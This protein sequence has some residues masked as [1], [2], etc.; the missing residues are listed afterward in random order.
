MVITLL[1]LISLL[2]LGVP[3]TVTSK[4]FNFAESTP[5]SEVGDLIEEAFWTCSKDMSIDILSSE[6]VLPSHR[7]RVAVEDLGFVDR[8]AT[9]PMELVGFGLVKRLREYGVLTD[10]TVVDIKSELEGKALDV[11]Q[12]VS[13]FRPCEL[14]LN[15]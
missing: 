5:S 7:V 4:A 10:I 9:L 13:P 6:G 15:T 1:P 14:G 2:V 11:L 12:L 3:L 8:I